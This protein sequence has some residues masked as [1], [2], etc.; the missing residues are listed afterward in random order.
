MLEII[1][2]LNQ[3]EKNIFNIIQKNGCITKKEIINKTN[4]KLTSLTRVI[5]NL[6]KN[7]LIVEIGVAESTGGRKPVIYDVNTQRNYIIG[8]DISRTYTNVVI[9]NLKME[10]LFKEKFNMSQIHTPQQTIKYISKIIKRG[11]NELSLNIDNIF[12]IG[13][14]TIGPLDRNEGKLLEVE[15][16]IAD[17]WKNV[18]IK[19]LIEEEFN[20]PVLVD[21]GANTAVSG[22]FLYG[23]GKGYNNIAYFNIGVGI[24][25]GTITSGILI[26]SM[27]D[28]EDVFGHMVIDVDGEA[29][30]CGNYGC[31]ECYSTISSIVNKFTA[32]IKKGRE[33]KIY[34]KIEDINYVDICNAA[35]NDD[36]LSKEI[37]SDAAIIF[38]TGLANFSSLLN[39]D[40]IILSGPLINNSNLF[41]RVS[42]EIAE[43]KSYLKKEKKI[44]FS[45][46]GY[47]KDNV[48]ATGSAAM[49]LEQVLSI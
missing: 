13:L 1:K 24:R 23:H 19:S 36:E 30:S 49:F 46:G 33:S 10:I 16:F 17:G 28:I 18:N 20:I 48:I 31:I 27:N 8:I 21:N 6:E 40:L 26:R 22:E 9:I 32:E 38:G 34:K 45:N 14:G 37:I 15:K 11:V 41:Y 35:E 7:E 42:T 47:Y 3:T 39:V 44:S 5:N 25:T 12:G 29:C 4:I 2:N 43:K